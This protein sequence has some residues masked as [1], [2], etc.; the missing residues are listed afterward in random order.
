MA[1]FSSPSPTPAMIAI[2]IIVAIVL[3]V[4]VL[5]SLRPDT[6]RIERVI[7]IQAPADR[8][9]PWLVDFRKWTSWSP[10]ENLDPNLQRTYG[11]AESGVGATYAWVGDRRVGEGRMEILEATPSSRVKI[12]LQFIKPF[13]ANNVVELTLAPAASGTQL[14]WVMTG[15]SP[16]M[17]KLFGLFMNMD[18]MIGKDFEKG[19]SAIKRV[20]E[21]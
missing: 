5:A 1:K 20:A 18:A 7:E 15:A 13:A 12:A 8:I 10:W 16:F 14:S 6:M 2:Y 19:L 9:F 21:G 17:S 4:L 11:G 3:V